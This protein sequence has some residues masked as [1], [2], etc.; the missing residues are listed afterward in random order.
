MGSMALGAVWSGAAVAITWASFA[1]AQVRV[2]N[3]N[4]AELR[5]DPAAIEQVID[6]ASLD[7]HAGFAAPVAIMLL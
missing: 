4:L 2:V 5:G 6:A 7:D 3:W 1:H